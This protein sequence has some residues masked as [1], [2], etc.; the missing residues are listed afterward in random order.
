MAAATAPST[1][2]AGHNW[3]RDCF[4]D[5]IATTGAASVRA[6]EILS[7]DELVLDPRIAFVDENTCSGCLNCVGVCPFNA[8]KP[9]EVDGK[10]VAHILPTVCH[11]C[12][13]CAAT[14]RTGA[15]NVEGFS[16]DQIYAQVA[17]VFEVL[18]KESFLELSE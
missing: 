11:G 9:K 17:S 15:A 18:R 2:G 13:T 6:V 1:K 4:P 8:I 10:I 3:T 12:G 14:C 7:K 5:S 16:D